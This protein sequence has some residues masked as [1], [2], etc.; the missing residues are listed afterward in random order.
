MA[1]KERNA[2]RFHSHGRQGFSKA[3]SEH[4]RRRH[5][6]KLGHAVRVQ[7]ATGDCSVDTKEG[8]VLAKAGDAILT[9]VEGERWRVSRS[10]FNA[11][12]HPVFPTKSGEDGQ[13]VSVGR[14]II[15]VQMDGDFDVH[16]PDGVSVLAGR[17]GDWL[18]DYGDGSLGVVSQAIFG[19]TYEVLA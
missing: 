1:S 14:H 17:P 3:I 16:L 9:G 15:A 13:Y 7:F 8:A 5:A 10:R 6:R 2:S 18:V 19:S 4:P 12:Y 11:N